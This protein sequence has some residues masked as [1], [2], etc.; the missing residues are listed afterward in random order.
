VEDRWKIAGSERVTELWMA[1]AVY[2]VYIN[3]YKYTYAIH[4]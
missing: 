3:V 1:K 4:M 2:R